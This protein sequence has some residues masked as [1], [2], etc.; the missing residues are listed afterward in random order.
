MSHFEFCERFVENIMDGL[1]QEILQLL[2]ESLFPDTYNDTCLNDS[3]DWKAVFLEMRQQTVAAL[4]RE[5]LKRHKISDM[6]L[7]NEWSK[8]CIAQM[9]RWVQI[10]CAQKNVLSLLEENSIKCVIIK[11]VAA[12]MAYPQPALRAAGD[13]D[14][15]VKRKDYENA[16]R[17][18]EENGY[19]LVGEKD[20]KR[21]HY[22]YKKN[23]VVF[24]LHRRLAD[25]LESDEE[26]LCLFEEGVDRR[27]MREVKQ[28]TFPVL[29]QELNGLALLLHINQHLRGGLGLRQIID[30]MMYI[31]ENDGMDQ[32]IPLLKRT[33]MERFANSVTVMCQKYL[34]LGNFVHDTGDYPCEKLINYIFMKGNFGRKSGKEGKITGTFLDMSD[35]VRV[36]RRLQIGGMS[37][38]TLAKKYTILRPFAWAFQIL[39]ISK[40]LLENKISLRKMGELQ[41]IGQQQRDLI[42]EL[43]LNVEKRIKK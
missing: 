27:E 1:N 29:P 12:G 17:V 19:Q 35:I 13:I 16:A 33:G 21:H 6:S 3:C 7:Y 40:Y 43:G 9:R 38:W 26:L 36:F 18:L 41:K 4:P 23:T 30:W 37:R 32:L 28:F 22:V 8:E 20:P 39:H 11:G 25:I 5:W 24:E 14:L 15:L 10:M 2:K 31:H 42:I 34:G